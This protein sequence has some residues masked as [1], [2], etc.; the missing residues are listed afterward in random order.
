MSLPTHE[1]TPDTEDDLKS[2]A[3]TILDEVAKRQERARLHRAYYMKLA[4][5]NGATYREI[6]EALGITIP[7]V[8]DALI[9]IGDGPVG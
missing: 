6:G 1:D 8:R 3:L 7:S 2:Y 9:R 4:R 5:D